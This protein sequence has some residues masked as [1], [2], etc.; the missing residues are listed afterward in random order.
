MLIIARN[1]LI[2]LPCSVSMSL[3]DFFQSIIS[4]FLLST[5]IPI[6]WEMFRCVTFMQIKP[7]SGSAGRFP[8]TTLSD[9]IDRSR[10]LL[11]HLREMVDQLHNR[12][13]PTVRC[14]LS[15]MV[16]KRGA[17]DQRQRSHSS[18]RNWSPHHSPPSLLMYRGVNCFPKSKSTTKTLNRIVSTF[19]IFRYIQ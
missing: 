18:W 15:E 11:C 8:S 13:W 9:C 12:L 19:P 5:F 10:L 3:K 16:H 7:R 17:F 2:H 4:S 14:F 6:F 1:P